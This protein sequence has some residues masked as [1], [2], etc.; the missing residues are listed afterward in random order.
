MRHG[1]ELRKYTEYKNQS[2]KKSTNK[3]LHLC[4][5]SG[6]N[7][8]LP[9]VVTLK[10]VSVHEE[11]ENNPK[12]PA[13]FLWSI[14]FFILFRC[15]YIFEHSVKQ[16]QISNKRFFFF[17]SLHVFLVVVLINAKAFP[18]F[19][20]EGIQQLMVENQ[21]SFTNHQV[22]IPEINDESIGLSSWGIIQHPWFKFQV[23]RL[24]KLDVGLQNVQGAIQNYKA[25]FISS[26]A[27]SSGQ[28]NVPS[29]LRAG[30]LRLLVDPVIQTS[31]VSSQV[32]MPAPLLC[33]TLG[34][35]NIPRNLDGV[36]VHANSF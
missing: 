24:A 11:S 22:Q 10:R 5:T 7:Q 3:G 19:R 35:K 15:M 8:D 14:C 36:E 16:R 9:N 2:P 18:Y 30:L 13:L 21:P 32:R 17:F 12:W 20:G 27:W 31:P 26:I 25:R 34:T 4:K 29:R 23:A 28:R 6:V 1:Q 33:I